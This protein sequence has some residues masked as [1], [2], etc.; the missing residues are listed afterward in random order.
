MI[1]PSAYRYVTCAP[2][3]SHAEHLVSPI[4]L[5]ALMCASGV[6]GGSRARF[7]SSGTSRGK[8]PS[9]SRLLIFCRIWI[10]SSFI[11][12]PPNLRGYRRPRPC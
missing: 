9:S 8:V 1:E 12:C 2:S 6:P 4:A 7:V 11:P 5:S 3:S 10:A